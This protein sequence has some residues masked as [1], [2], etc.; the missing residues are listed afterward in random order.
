MDPEAQ[1]RFYLKQPGHVPLRR[2]L[3]LISNTL[4]TRVHNITIRSG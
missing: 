4:N 1:A 2:M 3:I